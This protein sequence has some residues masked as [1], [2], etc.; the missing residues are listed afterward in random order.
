MPALASRGRGRRTINEIN[1]VPFIDVMLVLLI[2]FMV[3]APMLTPGVIDVP[4]VG[5][6]KNMP[7]VVAQVIVNKDSTLQLKTPEATR[8]MN[9]REIGRAA[10]AWQQTQGKDTAVVITADK[11]VQYETVV[12]AMDALQKAGVQRVGLSVKQGG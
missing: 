10:L 2:I 1:M 5:K 6:G 9:A 11:G 8:S 4:S 7:K 12:K 3:T